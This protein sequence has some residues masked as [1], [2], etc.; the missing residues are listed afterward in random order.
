MPKFRVSY[1]DSVL[2]EAVVE[3]DSREQAEAIAQRQ[4]EQGKH[5]HASDVW[6]DDWQVEPYRRPSPD[7]R[8][9]FE[10]GEKR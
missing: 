8:Y 6:I 1:T 7:N 4:M 2:R 9:C 10:C 5:H 3:A